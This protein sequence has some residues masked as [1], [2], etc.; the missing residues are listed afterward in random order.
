MQ[1][2]ASVQL[3]NGT[4]ISEKNISRI[5]A[6]SGNETFSAKNENQGYIFRNITSNAG[7]NGHH[8]TLRALI[9]STLVMFGND[10]NIYINKT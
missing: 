5:S 6:K 9:I 4:Y 7:I 2:T 10:F 8:K 3:K 1:I